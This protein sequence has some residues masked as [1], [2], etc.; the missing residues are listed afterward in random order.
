MNTCMARTHWVYGVVLAAALGSAAHADQ[1]F[2]RSTDWLP[3]VP[4]QTS[5]SPGPGGPAIWIYEYTSGGGSLADPTPWYSTPSTAMTWDAAWWQTGRGVW[6]SGDEVSPPVDENRTA[7][8]VAASAI[9]RVP[10]IRF[11]NPLA[12]TELFDLAGQLSVIWDGVSG[13]GRP[14]LVDVIVGKQNVSG[15]NTTILFADSYEKPNNFASIGDRVDVGIELPDVQLAPGESIIISHRGRE[16]VAPGGWIHLVDNVTITTIPTPGA[17][18]LLALGG[19]VAI[20][21][22]R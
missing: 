7:H 18:T 4:G 13:V 2:D 1:I 22:R 14:T 9:S 5:G 12:T 11:R 6:S 21:R 10:I 17:V 15:T 20:R 16:A 19:I 8:N 3:G